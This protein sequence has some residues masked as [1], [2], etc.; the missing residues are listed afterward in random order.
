VK[1]KT[2]KPDISKLFDAVDADGNFVPKV[3]D[4]I[5]IQYPQAWKSTMTYKITRIDHESGNVFM[6]SETETGFRTTNFKT[7]PT[8][9]DLVI[10][11]SNVKE[12]KEQK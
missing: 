3:G 2:H 1:S 9:Y 5:T 6:W 8:K 12:K 7:G 4:S 11:I 10:K